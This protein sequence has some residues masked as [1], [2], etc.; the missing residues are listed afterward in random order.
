M[1]S[2]NFGPL[3]GSWQMFEAYDI[4]DNVPGQV[5]YP[6]GQPPLGYWV[7]DSAGNFALQISINPALPV[8]IASSWWDMRTDPALQGM[9]ESFDNYMAYFG[10][11][12]VDYTTLIIT[13]TVVADVLRAYTGIPQDRPFKLED[14][15]NTLI[16]G[17]PT[18]YIRKF[19]RV[20]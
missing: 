18:S 20:A 8:V 7:Y 9:T 10:T 14:D 17:D 3:V 4:G 1:S 13:H 5:T 19:K 2:N 16:I 11:Y 6:W 15:N 12:K